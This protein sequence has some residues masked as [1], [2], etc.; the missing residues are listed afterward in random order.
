MRTIKLYQRPLR[1]TVDH[2]S[3]I[4]TTR[5]CQDSPGSIIGYQGLTG[6]TKI[7]QDLTGS[8][9][10]IRSVLRQSLF[11]NGDK[12]TKRREKKKDECG[13]M[14]CF[15]RP[16]LFYIRICPLAQANDTY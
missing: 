4:G 2:Q 5:V 6:T 7:Y 10:T 11:K 3:L 9:I 15:I 1:S 12:V 16:L 8:I 14:V 13:Q